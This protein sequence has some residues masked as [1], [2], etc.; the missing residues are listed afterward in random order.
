VLGSTTTVPPPVKRRITLTASLQRSEEQKSLQ[1]RRS[2]QAVY[3]AV[4]TGNSCC[5]TRRPL[6]TLT[7]LFTASTCSNSCG[8]PENPSTTLLLGIWWFTTTLRDNKKRR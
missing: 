3:S 5:T 2:G 4:P 6:L 8:F 1:V 7:H